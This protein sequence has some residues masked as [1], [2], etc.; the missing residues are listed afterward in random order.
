M[1]INPRVIIEILSKSTEAYDRGEKFARYSQLI[2]FTDYILV[3]QSRP[4]IE[5]WVRQS[6]GDWLMHAETSIDGT[7]SISSIGCSLA[8]AEVYDG[9]DFTMM[10]ARIAPIEE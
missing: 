10:R 9:I 6:N 1:L 4:R 3:A 8:L 7:I 2:S 5:H